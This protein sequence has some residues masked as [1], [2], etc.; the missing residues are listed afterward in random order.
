MIL[1]V[2]V[3]AVGTY[4]L[5]LSHSTHLDTNQTGPSNHLSNFVQP[6]LS[7]KSNSLSFID[8]NE[9]K[10]ND[11]ALIQ[12]EPITLNSMLLQQN[13]PSAEVGSINSVIDQ[14][15]F[16]N[17]E[18]HQMTPTSAPSHG[19]SAG[20]IITG[21]NGEENEHIN[22][23]TN[24]WEKPE[25]KRARLEH[26]LELEA[27]MAY[28]SK[29]TSINEKKSNG[30]RK[31]STTLDRVGLEKRRADRKERQYNGWRRTTLEHRNHPKQDKHSPPLSPLNSEFKAKVVGM[32]SE[33]RKK[34]NALIL[35]P[36]PGDTS[37][38]FTI[39]V[40]QSAREV[41]TTKL[42]S[43]QKILPPKCCLGC[44]FLFVLPIV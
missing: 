3:C 13:H 10:D 40:A 26:E 15:G 31:G 37:L 1:L 38:A 9:E 28:T 35:F 23:T 33:H 21:E 20:M 19:S 42:Y 2:I 18:T 12:R 11:L 25:W 44:F 8:G 24:D 16:S 6:T 27:V 17:E 29:Q 22:N 43:V 5:H 4:L 36:M 32:A 30:A 34:P 41:T 7:V 14:S 39:A